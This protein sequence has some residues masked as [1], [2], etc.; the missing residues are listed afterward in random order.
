MRRTLFGLVVL[1]LFTARVEAAERRVGVVSSEAMRSTGWPELMAAR[2]SGEGGISLVEREKVKLMVDEA[3]LASL[4][5]SRSERT[6]ALSLVKA[7]VLVVLNGGGKGGVRVTVCDVATAV[8]LAEFEMP[9][10]GDPAGA[11]KA[12]DE[13]LAVLRRFPRGVSSIVAVPDFLCRDLT[14]DRN[15]LQRDY[16]EVIRSR[17]GGVEGAALVAV[18]EAREIAVERERHGDG[19]VLQRPNPQFLQG[20]F[21]TRR[22][23]GGVTVRLDLKLSQSD[24]TVLTESRLEDVGLGDVGEK[25]LAAFA[26]DVRPHLG[27]P[28]GAE[29]D[30]DGQFK[31]LIAQADRFYEVGD[32]V[33]STALREAALIVKPDADDQRLRLVLEYNR[34]NRAPMEW[35]EGGTERER[36]SKAWTEAVERSKVCWKRSLD[37][38]EYLVRN[39]RLS[40]ERAAD[41]L[42]ETVFSIT[43]IRVLESERIADLEAYKKMFV[44]EVMVRAARLNPATLEERRQ[45]SGYLMIQPG[46]NKA[47]LF[48]VDGNWIGRDDVDLLGDVLTEL[49]AEPLVPDYQ[50]LGFLRGRGNFK[51]EGKRPTELTRAHYDAFLDRL[52]KSDRALAQIYGRYGKLCQRRYGETREVSESVLAEAEAIVALARTHKF[53]QG[54]GS[55]FFGMLRDEVSWIKSQLEQANA[56]K[57]ASAAGGGTSTRPRGPVVGSGAAPATRRAVRMSV[58]KPESAGVQAGAITLEPLA[59]RFLNEGSSEVMRGTRQ[60]RAPGWWGGLTSLR[61]LGQL[62]GLWCGGA[63]VLFDGRAEGRVVFADPKVNLDGVVFDGQWIW[64]TTSSEPGLIVYDGGGKEVARVGRADGLP[65]SD[66]FGRK[67]VALDRGRVLVTGSFGN[68]SRGWICIVTFEAG[69][70]RCETIL[71]ATKTMDYRGKGHLTDPDI[72]VG[73]RPGVVFLATTGGDKPRR[74]VYIMRYRNPLVVDVDT[75]QVWVYPI[76]DWFKQSFPRL[77]GNFDAFASID[78]V[79][80]IAGSEQDVLS[81]RIAPETGLLTPVRL[82]AD[83]H[84]GNAMGGS[85]ARAGDWLYYAG[86]QKWRRINLKTGAEEVLI[87]DPRQ[88]PGFGSGRPWTLAYSANFGLLAFCDGQTYRVRVSENLGK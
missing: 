8:N 16:A 75:K 25:L 32:F 23:N 86:G 61:A 70:V 38:C 82:R 22:T 30:L 63:L 1:T 44:R 80:W 34:F 54:D 49:L 60:W 29:A 59:I 15:Y 5:A 21:R 41:L 50:L 31:Q 20:E 77:E 42:D 56:K 40:R 6:A 11:T 47:I 28:G 19:G 65:P 12:A 35:L 84:M 14:F 68:E 78:G 62:D 3:K 13:V 57:L 76:T 52:C 45:L 58:E 88:L 55:H 81:F 36:Q 69:A 72:Q 24:G 53:D 18:D 64:A 37:H 74:L 7:D 67:V 48:R 83:W 17:V 66:L 51:G 43:G 46:I 33:R 2:L 79:L 26:K 10:A 27:I 39:G 71:E 9:K 73:F 4:T 87:G 85:L